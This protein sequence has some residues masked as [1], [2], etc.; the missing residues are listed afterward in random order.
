MSRYSVMWMIRVSSRL[1]RG[2]V[3]FYMAAN[4]VTGLVGWW[5]RS[6][7]GQHYCKTC[8]R[9]NWS[10]IKVVRARVLAGLPGCQVTKRGWGSDYQSPRRPGSRWPSWGRCT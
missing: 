3:S 4:R 6:S 9:L 2:L 1:S 7:E 10:I 5:C 8:H